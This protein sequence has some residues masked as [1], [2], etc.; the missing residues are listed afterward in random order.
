MLGALILAASFALVFGLEAQGQDAP[1]QQQQQGQDQ[2]PGQVSNRLTTVH[3]I[4]RVASGDPLPRALV[5]IN[6]DASTGALTDGEGRFEISD[7]PEGPLDFTVM[8]PGFLDQAEADANSIGWNERGYGYNVI[9]APGMGDV[10]FTM[11]PVNSI[12]GQIQLS[13]GD[14]A[15]GILLTLLKRT[16]QD[17]RVVWQAADS[18]RT[19]TEGV[20]RFGGLSNGLYA[21]FTMPAMDSDT[22]SNLIESGAAGRMARSGYPSVFYPDARD[23]AGAAKIRLSGGEQTQANIALD[24]EPFQPVMATVVM[25]RSGAHDD[26]L[27]L[28]V[29]D[30]QGHLLPYS[31]Q[32]DPATHT[33][34][35][36]LPDGTYSVVAS[37]TTRMFRIVAER[38]SDAFNL[39]PLASRGLS[40]S[41]TFSVADR[42]VS[43][44]TLPMGAT[45]SSPVQVSISRGANGTA[46]SGDPRVSVTL[47]Q[48][49]GWMSDGMVSS[50]AEGSTS[51]SLQTANMQPGSY[52]V[53]TSIGPKTLCEASF[54]AGGASLA[55]EPL[56][57]GVG[58]SVAPL[59]LA[60]RDDCAKLTLSL[61]ASVGMA[62]GIEHAY[63]V[64]VVPDF[65]STEDVIPQTL[66]PSSGGSVTLTGLTPGNY[67]VYAFDGPVA[68]EYRN[69]E[70]LAGAGGQ[71]VSLPPGA[72]AQLTVEVPQS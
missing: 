39:T 48:T 62:V 34:Q 19:N 25:P 72:E 60:L 45:A 4:V 37:M 21:V 10:V 59:M 38:N 67:H 22:A 43:N 66:R 71:P 18:A 17:G 41:V 20:Y 15:E 36:M 35:A 69:R 40:G 6:G 14:V 51:G 55:R 64:Y 30:A 68:L 33:A 16:I 9:V 11:E 63:T 52:W 54:T 27:S 70:A 3:G 42:A 50:Y 44:L 29:L 24:L 7:V 57:L 32:Y 49:G 1:G 12:R 13:T 61:P 2:Q 23:L 65:E 58:G 28:Q 46:Q 53:H 31:A 47:S 56:V 26:N 8:K 5:R